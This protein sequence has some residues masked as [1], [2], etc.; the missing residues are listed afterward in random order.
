MPLGGCS[1][2]DS[3]DLSVELPKTWQNEIATAG[4][5]PQPLQENWWK[6]ANDPVLFEIME[7]VDAQNLS[8]EQAGYRLLAARQDIR[9][10]NYLP[11]LNAAASGIFNRQ[12]ETDLPAATSSK[13][14]GYY[15][16]GLDASWEIPLWGQL[17]DTKDISKGNFAYAL[18]DLKA[19]R[20]S[21]IAETLNAYTA[22]R[23]SQVK[24]AKYK[25]IKTA[26]EKVSELAKIQLDVG[27]IAANDVLEHSVAVLTAQADIERETIVIEQSKQRLQQLTAQTTPD[28]AWD[29][30]AEIPVFVVPSVSDT[31]LDVIRNRP[32]IARAEAGVLISAA[33]LDLA[34]SELYP[35]LTLSGTLSK[36]ANVTGN[37]LLANTLDLG[38]SPV[39]SLPLFDWSRRLNNARIQE[40]GLLEKSALYR[41]T[42]ID[43]ISE[44]QLD[45]IALENAVNS[46]TLSKESAQHIKEMEEMQNT[47]FKQG[48]ISQIENELVKIESLKADILVITS[49]SEK[50]SKLIAFT[51]SLG[52]GLS[53]NLLE[54]KQEKP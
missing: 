54:E 2:I 45:R 10:A 31:P 34:R 26:Y 27:L 6:S 52:G 15:K 46:Y 22:L 49:Q 28:P 23:T 43:A 37:P 7:A 47:R 1:F 12:L 18:S 42:V 38:S 39:I 14:T 13:S 33:E 44:A 51:K 5:T 32:D 19:V 3:P 35:K 21:V 30:Y 17:S 50:I 8:L 4:H 11:N 29:K 40:A 41:Q 9:S 48:L 25:S 20:S 53:T 36:M 24:L 16:A